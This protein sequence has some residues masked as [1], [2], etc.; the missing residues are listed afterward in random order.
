MER[1]WKI[2]CDGEIYIGGC[3][4]WGGRSS[5]VHGTVII[6]GLQYQSCSCED[7]QHNRSGKY[8]HK[9]YYCGGEWPNQCKH[10]QR[11]DERW[12][13]PA[14]RKRERAEGARYYADLEWRRESA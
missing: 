10:L 3:R 6:P 2:Y 9:H 8:S 11:M 4:S 14:E 1:I 5:V 12:V 13:K 7:F